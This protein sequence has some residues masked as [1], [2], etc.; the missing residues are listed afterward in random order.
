MK[1][2]IIFGMSVMLIGS[3]LTCAGCGDGKDILKNVGNTIQE[4]RVSD[5]EYTDLGGEDKTY[6]W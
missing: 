4:K 5:K 2:M 1:K 6:Y 3:I